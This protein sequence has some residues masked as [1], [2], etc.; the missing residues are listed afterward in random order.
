MMVMTD[1]IMH[2]TNYRTTIDTEVITHNSSKGIG[3]TIN[4]YYRDGMY[5]LRIRKIIF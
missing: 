1:F 4:N 5:G 2:V 3:V